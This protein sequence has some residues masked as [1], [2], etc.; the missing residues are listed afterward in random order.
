MLFADIN[1]YLITTLNKNISILLILILIYIIL[2]VE[3][4]KVEKGRLYWISEKIW[5][6]KIYEKNK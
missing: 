1:Y 6:I 2:M 5:L 3:R 4:T